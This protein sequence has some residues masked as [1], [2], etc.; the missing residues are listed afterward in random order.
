[1]PA[2]EDQRLCRLCKALVVS[3]IA[4]SVHLS[5]GLNWGNNGYITLAGSSGQNNTCGQL[6]CRSCAVAEHG[7]GGSF[8]VSFALPPLCSSGISN[9]AINAFA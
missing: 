3:D 4:R 1:M 8:V 9:E 6:S 7:S 2:N 5:V